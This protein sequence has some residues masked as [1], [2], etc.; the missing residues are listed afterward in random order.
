[1]KAALDQVCAEFANGAIKLEVYQLKSVEV[2]TTIEDAIIQK[3][4]VFEKVRFMS[5]DR[6]VRKKLA[7]IENVKQIDGDMKIKQIKRTGDREARFLSVTA[8]YAL[9]REQEVNYTS[10]MGDFLTEYDITDSS[11]ALKL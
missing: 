10:K 4:L 6:Q 2:S 9:D 7:E 8:E 5:N 3:M 1:M 11:Q